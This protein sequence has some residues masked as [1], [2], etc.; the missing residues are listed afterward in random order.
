VLFYVNTLFS[1]LQGTKGPKDIKFIRA[2]GTEMAE[3][4]PH[5]RENKYYLER[6][7]AEERAFIDMQQKSTVK[8]LFWYELKWFVRRLK[9]QGL[10]HLLKQGALMLLGAI[11]CLLA[12]CVG[13]QKEK[14]L[15]CPV[16]LFGDSVI[17]ND[18][19]GKELDELLS[20]A[21]GKEVF[22]AG[23]GGSYLCNQ[24][25]DF[26]DT[27]GDESLSM[28]ELSMSIVSGSFLAQKT[29]IERASRLDYYEA[30]LDALSKVDFDKTEVII[31]EHGVNDYAMQIPPEQ[32]E[33]TLRSIIHRFQEHYPEMEIV[34][35]SPSYCYIVRDGE[36]L[37]CDTYE[38]GPH[39]LE[40]YVNV[41]QKVC[42]EEHIV[43]VDNYHDS[44]INKESLE[45]YSLDG[46]HLNEEGR[47]LIA[48]NIVKALSSN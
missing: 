10:K 34:I 39:T 47:T 28:E 36:N 27:C 32:F 12:V 48:E 15:E 5:F 38:M 11:I 29:A 33:E 6:V 22:N 37:Y 24:N 41:E 19:V 42:A 26:Y 18:Y 1:Y 35:C 8:M 30:R 21:L 4:F 40:E 31:L 46:L 9:Q 45:A 16:V 17:A 14:P 44:L 23:F 7:N 25:T 2:L 20:D 3:T 43:F 13:F